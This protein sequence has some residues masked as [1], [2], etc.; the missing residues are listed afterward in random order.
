[1]SDDQ[2]NVCTDCDYSDNFRV[3]KG[4]NVHERDRYGILDC[5]R[6]PKALKVLDGHWC[7]EFSRRE[8]NV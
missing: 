1:M 7:G 5:H 2:R 6:Y 8:G 3:E 4:S